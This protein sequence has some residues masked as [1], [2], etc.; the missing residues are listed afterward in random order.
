MRVLFDTNVLLDALLARE[1]CLADAAFLLAAIESGQI[2]G[3]VSATAITDVYY[4][5]ERHTRNP[6]IALQ[7][8]IQLLKLM[9]I[10]PIDRPV[11]ETALALG[12]TDFE[13]AIQVAAALT[14]GLQSIVTR[15]TTGFH[16]SPIPVINPILLRAQINDR[17]PE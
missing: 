3:F 14:F 7:A 10:C 16:G 17:I 13:D 15:D 12:L 2:Q 1:P 9:E 6:E 8:I 5:V 4:I 11:L